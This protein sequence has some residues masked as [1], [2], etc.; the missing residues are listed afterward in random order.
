MLKLTSKNNPS[1]SCS[2]VLKTRYW[3]FSVVSYF[4]RIQE[5]SPYILYRIVA[6]Q[7]VFQIENSATQKKSQISKQQ[8][9]RC[10]DKQTMKYYYSSLYYFKVALSGLT[11]SLETESLL[12]MMKNA[13]YF[14]LK[15]I[16]VLKVF[17]FLSRLS[18]DVVKQLEQKRKISFKIYDVTTCETNNYNA[19][20]AQYLTK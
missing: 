18:G 14:N 10:A 20:I 7:N 6:L 1:K 17:K 3:L 8:K 4:K 15:D 11:Q 12:K 19:L 5:I 16:F 9:N 2:K 13:F